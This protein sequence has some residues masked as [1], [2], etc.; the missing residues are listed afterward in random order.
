V[1]ILL[2]LGFIGARGDSGVKGEPMKVALIAA[3]LT[4]QASAL[5]C[6]TS[7]CNTQLHDAINTPA[8]DS[9]HC[10][11]VCDKGVCQCDP[12]QLSPYS[13]E[14]WYWTGHLQTRDGRKFGFANIVYTGI[15]LVTQ[16]PLTWSDSTVS[17]LK[18]GTF[19][20]GG[21]E[22]NLGLPKKVTNGFEFH[23]PS[24]DVVGGNGNDIIHSVVVDKTTGK[25]YQVELALHS[26]KSPVEQRADGLVFY[27]SREMM[28]ANGA[29]L[30]NGKPQV[31][32]GTVWFD[33]QF[34]NQRDAYQNVTT[35]QWFGIQLSGNRQIVLYDVE[36]S[37]SETRPAYATG[38]I[39]GT[40]NDPSCGVTHLTR[41]DFT[42][43]PLGTW[44]SAWVP[45][46]YGDFQCIYPMGW[47]IQIPSKH[48]NVNVEP[49]FKAQE[50]IS[51]LPSS[52]L[53]VG[54]RYWEGDSLVSGSDTGEA[55]VE[56]TGFCPFAPAQ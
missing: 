8:D 46:G 23:F 36:V 19:N 15:D 47:N 1:S 9:V 21:R 10:T 3:V 29:I 20:Y 24:S 50:I 45:T 43:T 26:V 7:N 30:I 27:Y 37:G 31:V 5:A 33:H 6:A 22:T 13:L 49:Y 52:T 55:F 40:Y 16:L 2:V 35:W 38:V 34:G 42:I 56:L 44:Q 4:L 41:N 32:E 14:W 25:K 17:D 11:T 53:T 54:D 28:Q 18:A 12:A 39:E 48:I 51:P